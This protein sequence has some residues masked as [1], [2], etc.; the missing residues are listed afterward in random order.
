MK[1]FNADDH[2][3]LRKGITNLINEAQGME[4]VGSAAD[5][6]EAMEKLRA[7]PP[8][9]AL[10]DIEMPYFSGLDVA[11]TLIKEGSP[12]RFVLLTLFKEKLLLQKA[13]S[14]GIKGY[15]LKE[16]NEGEIIDCIR[17]VH[18]GRAYVN[19]SM[20]D[21]LINPATIAPVSNPLVNLSNH[22]Q[23]ILKLIAREK[24]TTEIAGML[25]LSPKTIANH[26]NN[27]S[28]KLSLNGKQ[29]GLLKWA[30]AHREL[31]RNAN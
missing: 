4:W 30:L 8:D 25:F 15:L 20:T 29:N 22:E 27:I 5:G 11:T 16:S 31:L 19:A 10:L 23:N 2:P 7:N 3:I 28:K 13:L 14:A 24:T 9:V 1:V 12:T 21:F 17:A 6:R 18:N 26:R